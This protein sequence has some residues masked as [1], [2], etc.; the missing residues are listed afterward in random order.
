MCGQ[1]DEPSGYAPQGYYDPIETPTG[2]LDHDDPRPARQCNDP[3]CDRMPHDRADHLDPSFWTRR[4]AEEGIIQRSHVACC[5][6]GEHHE[7]GR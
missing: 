3:T 4:H 2:V 5:W 7:E 6:C 1:H